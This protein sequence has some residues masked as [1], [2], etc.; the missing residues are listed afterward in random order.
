M[1]LVASRLVLVMLRAAAAA[2]ARPS[3]PLAAVH[4]AVIVAVSAAAILMALMLP[5]LVLTGLVLALLVLTR[6]ML[7][8]LMLDRLVL[9]VVLVLGRRRLGS[10]GE[11][12]RERDRGNDDLHDVSP[13]ISIW[14]SRS[15][16]GTRRRRL[17][18]GMEAGEDRLGNPRGRQRRPRRRDE[19]GTLGLRDDR[20]GD[21]AIDRPFVVGAIGRHRHVG[22][23]GRRARGRRHWLM[24][25]H[26]R[27][28]RRNS[29]ER[30]EQEG[31]QGQ[32]RQEA[33]NAHPA[34]IARAARARNASPGARQGCGPARWERGRSASTG[35]R[36]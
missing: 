10:G 36:Q 34:R 25:R 5:G 24:M 23:M 16:G 29:S 30:R 17:G 8:L 6:L 20:A 15:S 14:V 22:T 33:A 13:W 3:H 31:H 21:H 18:L 35:P 26:G 1:A 27:L 4:P 11:G 7:T 9:S 28:G 32:Q 2:V 19:D 12:E